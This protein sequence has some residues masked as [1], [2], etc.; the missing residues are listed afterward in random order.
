[1]KKAF[2]V[3]IIL[4]A[5]FFSTYAENPSDIKIETDKVT[6]SS[7]ESIFINTGIAGKVYYNDQEI[8]IKEELYGSNNKFT[9]KRGYISST[10]KLNYGQEVQN[11][12]SDEIPVFSGLRLTYTG[13]TTGYWSAV[14]GYRNNGTAIDLLPAG[15]YLNKEI[16]ITD[17][18]IVKVV[19]WGLPNVAPAI[20]LVGLYSI[21]M[22][23]IEELQLKIGKYNAFTGMHGYIADNG[24][25][26]IQPQ[27]NNYLSDEL[28]VKQGDKIVFTG[29]TSGYWGA[30][31]GY[32]KDG[33]SILLLG[34][35]NY[36]NTEL[37]I[38]N[39]EIIKVRAWSKDTVEPVLKRIGND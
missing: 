34:A 2:I 30:L 28:I 33:T 1:M 17:N 3:Q 14:W 22:N 23:K 37:T 27:N 39:P 36:I 9:G 7:K 4:F 24:T 10:G 5:F 38:S 13:N 15:N 31:F 6:I 32:K 12:I 11:Y 8:A 26:I 16:I 20:N 21:L 35:N 29:A 19:A 25:I 18:S